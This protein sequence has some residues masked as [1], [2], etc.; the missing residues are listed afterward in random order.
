MSVK[1]AILKNTRDKNKPDYKE[2]DT[3]MGKGAKVIYGGGKRKSKTVPYLEKI[4][5]LDSAISS[6]KEE[7]FSKDDFW[8]Y[9]EVYFFEEGADDVFLTLKYGEFVVSLFRVDDSLIDEIY[10]LSWS[11]Y[12]LKSYADTLA[13]TISS[14]DFFQNKNVGDDKLYKKNP[15]F[16]KSTRV[17][18]DAVNQNTQR[19]IDRASLILKA[20]WK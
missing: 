2:L 6:F 5:L 18:I 10:H 20:G 1:C 13:G 19:L 12:H 14:L 7:L 11:K 16:I 15:A 8:N 9:P 17:M 3:A 4:H